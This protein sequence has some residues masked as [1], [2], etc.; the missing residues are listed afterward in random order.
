MKQ[1]SVKRLY[2]IDLMRSIV[3]V[4]LIIMHCMTMFSGTNP[5]WPLPE[6]LHAIVVYSWIQ[7]LTCAFLLEAFTFMS[8]YVYYFGLTKHN[9]KQTLKDLV[10]SKSKRLIV[11][12]ILFSIIFAILFNP[13]LF[14]QL[15]VFYDVLIGIGHLWYLPTLFVCFMI[16]YVLVRV[17]INEKLVFFI[18][19]LIAMLS[20]II[21]NYARISQALYFEFFFYTGMLAKK[22]SFKIKSKLHAALLLVVVI[23]VLL[24]IKDL[25]YQDSPSFIQIMICNALQMSCGFIGTIA[26]FTIC[27]YVSQEISPQMQLFFYHFS[28]LSMGIYI[29]Q[30]FIIRIIY[31]KTQLPQYL[32]SVLLP[33]ITIIITLIASYMLAY[34]AHNHKVGKILIG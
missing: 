15:R 6:G 12:S 17:N 32:G 13:S 21:P 14:G 34:F 25:F 22:H 16:S 11:P 10:V 33:W 1:D 23:P 2:D 19:L 24:V 20:F 18:L 29:I 3:I 9:G 26:L 31:Y 8:G 5:S 30:E 28:T 27:H 4:M 7:K